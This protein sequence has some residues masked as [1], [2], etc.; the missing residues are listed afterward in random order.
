M[1]QS[2]EHDVANGVPGWQGFVVAGVAFPMYLVLDQVISRNAAWVA[3]LFIGVILGSAVIFWPEKNRLWYWIALTS[4]TV[5]HIFIVI[6]VPWPKED[7]ASTM[8]WPLGAA[9]FAVTLGLM[10]GLS[11]LSKNLNW[12]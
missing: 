7:F 6:L 5:A 12:R 9:D 4:L 1:S 8:V 3:G 11:K 2:S 10:I